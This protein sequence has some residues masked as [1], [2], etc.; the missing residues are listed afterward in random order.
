MSSY[1]R[2]DYDTWDDGPRDRGS[3]RRRPY[4]DDWDYDRPDQPLKHSGMGI[5]SCL[6]A[7]GAGLFE[8]IFVVIAGV[9]ASSPQGVDE[10]SPEAIVLG[11]FIL[12]GLL[13]AVVGGVLGIVGATQANRNKL[14]AVLGLCLNGVIVVGVLG[15][16]VLGMAAG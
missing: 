1:P 10:N 11:L 3:R 2:D 9:M 8:F 14:F 6:I 12:G 7:L 16:M 13:A 15:L 5:A 4:D